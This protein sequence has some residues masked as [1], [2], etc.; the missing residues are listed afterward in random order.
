VRL[1]GSGDLRRKGSS[2]SPKNVL[3][4]DAVV[5]ALGVFDRKTGP[6]HHRLEKPAERR[7]FVTNMFFKFATAPSVSVGRVA[8]G[9]PALDPIFRFGQVEDA[10]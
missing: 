6:S 4:E 5:G 3:R 2:G 9:A 1:T 10:P 7:V 8:G